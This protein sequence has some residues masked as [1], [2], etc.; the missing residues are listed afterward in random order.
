[1]ELQFHTLT[2]L[3]LIITLLW[4]LV[5]SQSLRNIPEIGPARV[6]DAILQ[7]YAYRAFVTPKTGVSFD[8]I[9]P[10][11]L[12]GVQISAL[13]LR[14][15]SLFTRGVP[16]YREFK[17]PI[18]IIEEPYVERLVL[19]Y[20]NL[21]NRSK[22]YYPLPGY[23]YLAPVLGLLAYNGSDL[24][25]ENQ[26]NLEIEAS[27]DPIS[28]DFGSV[29]PAPDGSNPLCVWVNLHGEVNF[30]NVVSGT[31]CLAFKQGHFSIV[32]KSK[33]IPPPA[34]SL[35][36]PAASEALKPDKTNGIDSRVWVFVFYVAGGCVLL[37]LLAVLVLWIRGYKKRRKTHKMEQ[38]AE[39]GEP[40]HMTM[41]GSMK[42]PT[43]MVTRTQPTL[44][45]EYVP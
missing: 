8:G 28:I 35:V 44:E 30:T 40:L 3:I 4:P 31:R 41:I 15:G 13:R 33:P 21:G 1:M 36:P 19:V 9:V 11:N 7:N 20:Q 22:V 24:S 2:I 14:S 37:V 17:L 23:K 18:G 43:A 39:G 5:E 25:A 26:T 6:L 45:T 34:P 12:T 27:G 32:V 10:R 16:K 29:R 38:A 42:A